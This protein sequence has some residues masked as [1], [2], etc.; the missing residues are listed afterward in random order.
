MGFY[1]YQ[2]IMRTQMGN[3]NGILMLSINAGV[4]SGSINILGNNNE[5]H[6]EI[7]NDGSCCFTGELLTPMRCMKFWADG[8]IKEEKVN[9]MVHSDPYL[10][11][12]SGERKIQN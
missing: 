12:V 9:F 3:K 4:L 6:G 5:I 2:I 10:F 8:F 11:P 1:I 7:K